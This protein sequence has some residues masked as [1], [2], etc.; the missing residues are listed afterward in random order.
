MAGREHGPMWRTVR[1]ECF[2]NR[3]GEE[4][5]GNASGLIAKIDIPTSFSAVATGDMSGLNALGVSC[6]LLALCPESKLSRPS[7]D[8][9]ALNNTIQLLADST[10]FLSHENLSKVGRFLNY[11]LGATRPAFTNGPKE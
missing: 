3:S 2:L 9:L 7:M 6:R 8:T 11:R 5:V 10:A 4:I 1:F